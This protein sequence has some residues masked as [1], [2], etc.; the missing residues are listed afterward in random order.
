MQCHLQLRRLTWGSGFPRGQ[1]PGRCDSSARCK[2]RQARSPRTSDAPAVPA[3]TSSPKP[4][5]L[6]YDSRPP[7]LPVMIRLPKLVDNGVAAYDDLPYVVLPP[8][9]RLLLRRLAHTRGLCIVFLFHL[10]RG[11]V[12]STN[13]VYLHRFSRLRFCVCV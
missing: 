3:S 4:R 2:A 6:L 1:F 10:G 11:M 5:S 8:G 12:Y 9:I 13:H 7:I